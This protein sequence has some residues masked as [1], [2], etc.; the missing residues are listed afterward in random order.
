[1]Y[2]YPAEIYTEAAIAAGEQDTHYDAHAAISDLSLE[3]PTGS[4]YGILGSNGAGKTTTLR[5][6]MNIIA[7]DSGRI[8]LLG[9]DPA[10]D[11]GVLRK[12]GYMPEERG[13]YRKMTALNVICFFARLKGMS[14]RVARREANVWLARLGFS[15]CVSA[16]VDT[17][18]KGMQQKVQFV[19]TVIHKPALLILDEPAAGFDPVNQ[20]VLQDA[21][22]EFKDEGGTVMLSTGKKATLKELGRW[23]RVS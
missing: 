20:Q 5:M 6:I 22:R 18:S 8:S 17:L 10:I 19:A 2:H 7:R 13:L 14:E 15:D 1:M 12:V 23:L 4:I 11:R 16:R 21:S 9:A 3:V